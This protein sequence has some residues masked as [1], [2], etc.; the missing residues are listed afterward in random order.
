MSELN[1]KSVQ[2]T[3]WSLKKIRSATR[4]T[5]FTK[6]VM[7]YIVL[8]VVTF[9]L[10]FAT[11]INSSASK[12][13]KYID[14]KIGTGALDQEDIEAVNDYLDSVPV[15]ERNAAI[16]ELRERASNEYYIKTESWLD[17]VIKRIE[18]ST[19]GGQGLTR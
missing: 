15:G 16:A 13:I 6:G 10:S 19:L 4:R 12:E 14:N 1:G 18:S 2:A 5:V 17:D 11:N 7:P 8:I 9:I 3:D